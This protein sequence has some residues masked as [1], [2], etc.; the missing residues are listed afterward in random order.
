MIKLLPCIF[1]IASLCF[2]LNASSSDNAYNSLNTSYYATNPDGKVG[3][4]KTI[5]M[6]IENG[7]SS[8]AL[9]NWTSDELIAQG[10]ARDVAQAFK[11]NHERPVVDTYSIYGAYDDEYL[12]LGFQFVYTIWD[13][14]GEGKQPA[15]SK[16]YNM[17]GRMM[18]AFDLD[19]ELSTDGVLEDGETTPWNST[20]VKTVTFNNG[21]D[22]I[23]IC[24]TKPGVGTP[25]LFFP[26]TDGK[27]SYNAGYCVSYDRK[28][29]GY[30]DGLLPSITNIWGQESFGYDP[31]VLTGE[32]GFV[33]LINEVD[34]DA[35]T[36][37]EMRIPLSQL[38][39]TKEHIET[40]GIGV[41]YIDV[42]GSSAIGSVPYDPTV[43]DNVTGEYSLDSYSSAEK[44]DLDL[45]TY[46]MARIG[47]LANDQTTGIENVSGSQ[48][49]KIYSS[50]GVLIIES[51]T[52]TKVTITRAD[53]TS[54]VV[55]V[56]AGINHIDNLPKGFYI[57][58][59]T[60]IVL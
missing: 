37:Y 19:P 46:A 52:D 27:L 33:D 15:E 7:V 13:L 3:T 5:N 10:A 51:D 40:T 24:S 60:K 17:D 49:V 54:K 2:A 12:Y 4:N 20:G 43:Y 9:T 38:G 32:T 39:I 36:F 55:F 59:S 34:H 50:N 30:A 44:E 42:Y 21:T 48:A 41:M 56:D 57:V 16:P 28:S 8:T 26:N 35:H 23:L 25:G 58:N 1:T 31:A 14:N 11:G 47:K 18:I 29:Y 45:F 53:G 6:S 22:C